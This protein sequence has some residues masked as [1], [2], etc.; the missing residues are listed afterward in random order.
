MCGAVTFQLARLSLV[1]PRVDPLRRVRERKQ[2]GSDRSL[3]RRAFVMQGGEEKAGGSNLLVNLL[4]RALVFVLVL[5]E[6]TH[7]NDL[8]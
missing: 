8:V 5:H 4:E 1:A 7:A 3:S 2:K 6:V